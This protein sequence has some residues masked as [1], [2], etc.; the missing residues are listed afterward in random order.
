MGKIS[1]M[2]FYVFVVVILVVISV[3]SVDICLLSMVEVLLVFWSVFN[4]FS[5][6]VF[7]NWG[8]G[9]DCCIWK[10]IIC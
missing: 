9:G 5:G 8:N 1:C 7:I 4:D 3:C 6:M 2:K 10:G